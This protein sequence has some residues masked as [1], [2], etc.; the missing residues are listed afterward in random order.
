MKTVIE[1]I[2]AALVRLT[3]NPKELSE[4]LGHKTNGLVAYVIS[5]KRSVPIVKVDDWIDIL[6]LHGDDAR[7]FHKLVQLQHAPIGVRARIYKMEHKLRS[8][9]KVCTSLAARVYPT[10]SDGEIEHLFSL[11]E[12]DGAFK[13]EWV[14]LGE[15][16]R[17][18]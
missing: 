12:N 2:Q 16:H 8:L 18:K 17:A 5:G 4:K 13:Q 1:V 7:E 6:E 14:A 3:L 10:A 15:R 9:V 11:I